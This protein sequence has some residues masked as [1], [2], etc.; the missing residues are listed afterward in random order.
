M[1]NNAKEVITQVMQAY[2]PPSLSDDIDSKLE[3][4]IHA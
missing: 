3:A 4:I 1:R 2:T